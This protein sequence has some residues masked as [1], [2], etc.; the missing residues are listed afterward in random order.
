MFIKFDVC[1]INPSPISVD[2]ECHR[3]RVFHN[4]RSV[5]PGRASRMLMSTEGKQR[6]KSLDHFQPFSVIDVTN[7]AP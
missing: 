2:F 3:I 1:D 7:N 4:S 6:C 5:V